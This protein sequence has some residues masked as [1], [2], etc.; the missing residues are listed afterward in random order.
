[1]L[2]DKT[3]NFTVLRGSSYAMC[4]VHSMIIGDKT[5]TT[6]YNRTITQHTETADHQVFT[7]FS[8]FICHLLANFI[9][10]VCT[11]CF[12][13]ETAS[14]SLEFTKLHI[15]INKRLTQFKLDNRHSL[16]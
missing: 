12:A 11:F 9:L 2:T 6:S 13:T 1:M 8:H 16:W 4:S 15:L 14:Q 3:Q 10:N 5:E 7:P